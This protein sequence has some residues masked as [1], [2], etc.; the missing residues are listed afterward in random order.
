MNAIVVYDSFFGHTEKIAHAISGNLGSPIEVRTLRAPDVPMGELSSLDLLVVGSPTRVFRPTELILNFLKRIPRE[1]LIGVNIAAF[2]TRIAGS[3][4]GKGLR[5]FM[6]IGGYAAG[7]IAD[8]L[9]KKGGY[10]VVPP[11]GFFVEDREGPLKKGEVKRAGAWA[12]ELL[13]KPRARYL[14]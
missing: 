5:F 13:K 3:D 6:K 7:K 12:R 8:A 4:A 2:D 10:L 11:E 14:I 9:K 1:A